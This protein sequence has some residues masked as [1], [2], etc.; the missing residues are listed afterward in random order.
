MTMYGSALCLALMLAAPTPAEQSVPSLLDTLQGQVRSADAMANMRAVWNTDRWFTFPKFADTSRNMR[1]MLRKA[2]ARDVRIV[3]PPADGVT[4]YGFW[5]MPLAWDVRSATLTVEGSGDVLADY[6]REP[7]SLCMWSGPTPREGIAAELVEYKP[8]ADVRGKFVLTRQNPA[9]I[10]HDLVRAGVAGVVNGFSENIALTDG[11][12]WINAWGDAGWAF[13][14]KSTPLPCF[15]ATPDQAERLRKQLAGGARIRVRAKVDSRYYRGA[16]PYVTGT[17]PGVSNEEVLLL[18]HAFEQG[19]HD[20]ATGVAAMIEAIA[21]LNRGIRS[22]ALSRPK[23]TIRVLLMGEYYG[24]HHY[25]ASNPERVSRT[26]GA[27]CLDTPAAPYEAKGTEYTF[28]LNPH[29]GAA[30]TDV[31]IQEIAAAYF[32]KV[33]RPWK[34]APFMPGTDSFLGEPSIG[35]PATWPYSGT[36]IHTHHNSRDTPDTVDSRSLRDLTIV[37]AAYVYYLANA[38]EAEAKFLLR[39][40]RE[41]LSGT[42][43]RVAERSL[44]RLVPGLAPEE[45]IPTAK[46]PKPRRLRFGTIPLDDLPVDEREGF[47]SGAWA[48]R[49]GLALYWADGKRTIAEIA[50]LTEEEAGKSEF[51]YDAYFRFLARKGYVAL[52]E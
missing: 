50:A 8:G 51:N 46:G 22:G 3:N 17:L 15:S 39:G 41:R 10:K 2:G 42:A 12:Q 11:R 4:Q 6:S 29:S 28:H 13:T 52:E 31:L 18:G 9:G 14:A 43:A 24:T 47:P 30:Y 20:N 16:Y 27:F 5:T 36:G 34:T 48:A 25:I 33:G 26:V 40:I 37:A 32:P 23:R 19:A 35:I 1:A 7:A 45:P 49:P 44:N 21:A 38:G